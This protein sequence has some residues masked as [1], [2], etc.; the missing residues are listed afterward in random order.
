MIPVGTLCLIVYAAPHA[1][2]HVGKLCTVIERY[3]RLPNGH[4]CLIELQGGLQLDAA[5][6]CLLPIK[7]PDN[8]LRSETSHDK[9]VGL[10]T[11]V[12]S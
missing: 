10:R 6:K 9:P 5:D 7:P 4:E 11:C 2:C 8:P 3:P 1:R 12:S